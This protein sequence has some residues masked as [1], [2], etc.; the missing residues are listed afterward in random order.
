LSHKQI[1]YLET[2]GYITPDYI[3]VGGVRQR[4]Y[5]DQLVDQLV[6]ISRYRLEGYTLIIAVKLSREE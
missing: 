2:K 3:T 5:S 1:R 6:K 4:R